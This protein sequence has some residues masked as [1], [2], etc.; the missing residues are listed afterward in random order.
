VNCE[1]DVDEC[2]AKPCLNKG[3]CKNAVGSYSCDCAGTGFNGKTC[4][5]DQDEC[6]AGPCLHA[7]KCTNV[8]GSFS[9][10]CTGT[11]YTGATC[12]TDVDECT[13]ATSSPCLHGGKCSNKA[14]GFSC[15]CAITGYSGTTCQTDVNE[16][17]PAPG[18]CQNGGTC[19]NATGSYTC[20]CAGTG[21]AGLTCQNDADLCTPDPC[22]H[23][24]KCTSSGSTFSCNCN[25]TGYTG[26]TC[27]TDVNEC[28]PAPGPCL[29]GGV[30]KNAAGNFTC[31]CAGTGYSGTTCQTDADPCAPNP[32]KNAGT[33]TASGS[34]YTCSCGRFNGT[35]CEFQKFRGVG[36]LATD[37]ESYLHAISPD[38]SVAVGSSIGDS[39][40]HAVRFVGGTLQFLSPPSSEDPNISCDGYAANKSGTVLSGVCATSAGR[41]AF[42]YVNGTMQFLSLSPLDSDEML[43]VTDIS[44][45]GTVLVGSATTA[46]RTSA[47]FRRTATGTTLLPILAPNI[48]EGRPVAVSGDGSI[49]TGNDSFSVAT[50]W[51]WTQSTGI[52]ALPAPP[53]APSGYNV[54]DVSANGNVF[55]G[56]AYLNDAAHMLRWVGGSAAPIDWGTDGYLLATNADGSVTV[57]YN[58]ADYPNGIAMVWNAAGVGRTLASALGATSDMN[59]WTNTALTDIS[60]DGKWVV[61]SG[62]HNGVYEGFI[63]HLP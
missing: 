22:L 56:T 15:D 62:L 50:A 63:A 11:G 38:G 46:T 31:D 29:N 41:R 58:A 61:G 37:T 30:C 8:P 49:V 7:G 13:S 44:S 57:G 42:N 14:G 55:V 1:T 2:S 5:I 52:V 35:N 40:A 25:G 9:C 19:K 54:N 23:G 60:D 6:A 33:C 48:I 53:N 18:P 43:T 36:K 45:D 17:N 39:G 24:G 10:N 12:Q 34:G 51:R 27:Q 32:C 59:G 3:V 16:C 26:T 28:S 4:E 20:D 47:S 21:Y